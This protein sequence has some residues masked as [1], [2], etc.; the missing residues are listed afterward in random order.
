MWKGARSWGAIPASAKL[1]W[2]EVTQLFLQQN[3]P[4]R[5][6]FEG[7]AGEAPDTTG[8]VCPST[9]VNRGNSRQITVRDT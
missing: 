9:L 1:A 2:S 6:G 5:A 7:Y 3:S 8:C 4:Q